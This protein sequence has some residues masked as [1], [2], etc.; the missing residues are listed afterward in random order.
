MK[1][2][3]IS[4]ALTIAPL[5]VLFL[6][7]PGSRGDDDTKSKSLPVAAQLTKKLETLFEKYYPQASM[8]NNGVNGL[9]FGYEVTTYDF[10]STG[11]KGGKREADKRDGPKKGGILCKVYA[12]TG[13]YRGQLALGSA[14]PDRVLQHLLDRKVYKQLLM[15][16]YHPK[17]DTSLWVS[18]Q[19]PEDVD[20][21]FLKSFR[22]IMADFQETGE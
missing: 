18:L 3:I 4:I 7:S 22:Q 6:G 15:A 5:L 12:N 13:P 17:S 21:A 11:K 19:Y 10:S 20:E 8:S 2:P 1:Y 14:K 9:Y 16:P